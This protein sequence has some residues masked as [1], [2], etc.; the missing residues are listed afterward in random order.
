[1]RSHFWIGNFSSSKLLDEYFH[2]QYEDEEIP[3]S[4]FAKDLDVFFYDHDFLEYG[5]EENIDNLEESLQNY[6]YSNLWINQLK[7]KLYK[8]DI[9]NFNT[10][11]FMN[12]GELENPTD[13]KGEDYLLKY[14]GEIEY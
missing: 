4:K 12:T 7:F 13:C 5:F 10:I 14:V 6:S 11:V 8:L 2:E 9:H 3:I 1:M